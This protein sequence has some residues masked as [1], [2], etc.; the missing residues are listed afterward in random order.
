MNGTYGNGSSEKDQFLPTSNRNMCTNQSRKISERHPTASSR[1]LVCFPFKEENIAFVLKNIR[2]A[3]AHPRVGQ[4]LAVAYSDTNSPTWDAVQD[5]RHA[6]EA[7]TGTSVVLL[8]QRRLGSRREGKG[9]GMNTAL[10]YFLEETDFARIHF[11]DADIK[12]FSRDWIS[13]GEVGADQGYD[14]VRHYFARSSTDG[15]V[16]WFITKVGFAR[17]WPRSVLSNIEQPLGGE[18][19]MTRKAA[20]ICVEDVRV[21]ARSDWG[22]D[23]LYTFALVQANV[24]VL[25]IYSREGKVH[26]LYGGLRDIRSM[27]LECFHAIQSLQGEAA[28]TNG[29]HRVMSAEPPPIEITEKVGYSIEKSMR[30]LSEGW[31]ARQEY[32]LSAF[33]TVHISEGMVKNKKWP[34]FGFMDEE[35]WLAAFD[36]FLDNFDIDD[37]D[38]AELLFKMWVARV[39]NHTVNHCVR[40]YGVAMTRLRLYI[41]DVQHRF[42][43]MERTRAAEEHLGKAVHVLPSSALQQLERA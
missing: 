7:E 17:L 27:V 1:S 37:A 41:E 5:A 32:L 16:T 25:E 34:N 42:A 19:V 14:L 33:F 36:I 30:L 24:P 22:I 20:K 40:G 26:A 23:T 10:R 31:T 35:A 38:W 13:R 18:L 11:Y 4:V 15:M 29:V 39:L 3:A 12:S 43:M 9:D 21:L 6:I 8:L 28:P 2:E